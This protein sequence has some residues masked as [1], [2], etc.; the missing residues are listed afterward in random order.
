MSSYNYLGYSCHPEV[1]QAAKDALD[2]YGLGANSSPV[3]GGQLSVHQ[4]LEQALVKFLDWSLIPCH[5]LA[6]VML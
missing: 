4:H 6:Q 5:C 3:I 1:I 2:Q